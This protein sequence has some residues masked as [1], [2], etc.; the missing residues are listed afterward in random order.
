MPE[1]SKKVAVIYKSNYGTTKRYAEWIAEEVNGDLFERAAVKISDLANYDVII[2]G[3]SLHAVG[4]KGVKLIT[5]NFNNLQDK[6]VIVYGVG[7]S[8]A[9][10]EAFRAVFDKNFVDD[11]KEKVNFFMLRGAF[12]YSK[13]SVGDKVLM[14]MLKYQL[15]KKKPEELD[16][17]MKGLL[18]CY[19]EPADWTDKAAIAP[20]IDCIYA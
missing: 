14:N 15:E 5:D 16:E 20:I 4:I 11:I 10:E 7:A 1:I 9:R 2:Y 19:N 18:A 13:L 3:G 17:D 6:K 8:P 12:D